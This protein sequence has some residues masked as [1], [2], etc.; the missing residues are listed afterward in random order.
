MIV[1]PDS[2]FALLERYVDQLDYRGSLSRRP[3]ASVLRR[4]QRFVMRHVAAPSLSQEVIAAWLQAEVQ[5]SPLPMV[6]RRAQ[7]VDTFLDWLVA[8]KHLPANPFAELREACRPHGTRSIVPALVSED[9][10]AALARLRPL[11]RYGSCVGPV[12]RDHVARMRTLG[13]RCNEDRFLRFDRFVQL[14]PGAAVESLPALMQAYAA[15]GCSPAVQY[16]H[17]RVARLLARALHRLDPSA[18][19]PPAYDPMV[20]R[21]MFRQR[22]Q[23][24]IYSLDEIRC[25]L[26]TARTFPSPHAPL[27]PQTLHTMILLAYCAGLRMG[28]LVRLQLRDFQL[29]EGTL[30]IRETKF[31][32]SRR[33]PLKASV[34]AALKVYLGQRAAAGLPQQR[35]GPLF[36][37]EK[38]G[39]AFVTAEH[40]LTRVIRAAGLKPQPGRRGPRVH[41]LRHTFVVHRMLAWYEQ[42]INPQ[43]RLPYLS[44]YLGHRD[45]HSTLVYL[46]ITQ[47]LLALANERFR[48]LGASA[49]AAKGG[50]HAHDAVTAAPAAGLLSGMAGP[51]AGRFVAYR[52]RLPRRLAAVPPP[53][54][55][56]AAV[57]GRRSHLR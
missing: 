56:A 8:T 12:L 37:S 54:R 16:E 45:I 5:V 11:P 1:W 24:Y 44:T 30:D 4:F 55:Q 53:G 13:Y 40:L 52:A 27:R 20:K 9:P 18:P 39:Y 28:E 10:E 32:K 43:S 57:R 36:C 49:L 42:G 47:E 50:N 22:R 26:R 51:S 33:L 31:F 2:S 46:T 38:G 35:D 14:R 48:V 25:L 6:I 15:E 17:L 29:E 23:P 19:V 7:I 3:C 41:D 21:A 34:V